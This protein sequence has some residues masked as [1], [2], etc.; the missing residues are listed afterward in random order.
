LPLGK[1]CRHRMQKQRQK[2]KVLTDMAKN[3]GEC[4]E[5][6]ESKVGAFTVSD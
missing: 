3:P 5:S 4:L 6:K 1:T 2:G